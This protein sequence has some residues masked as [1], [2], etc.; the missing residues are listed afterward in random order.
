VLV[1]LSLSAGLNL[2]PHCTSCAKSSQEILS[3]SAELSWEC[4]SLPTCHLIFQTLDLVLH[5]LISSP[6][7]VS[8]HPSAICWFKA[9]SHF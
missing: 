9:H 1:H 3:Q 7:T 4:P 8:G 6:E 5:M 2:F